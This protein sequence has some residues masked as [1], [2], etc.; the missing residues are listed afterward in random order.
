MLD[1]ASVRRWHFGTARQWLPHAVN[2]GRF[3]FG[4]VC[5]FFCL[6]M[7]YLRSCWTD[8]RQI[9][10]KEVFGLSLGRVWRFKGQGHQGQKRHFWPFQRPACVRF[11]LGKTSLVS[12][13]ITSA[14]SAKRPI[15][16]QLKSASLWS[17]FPLK[18]RGVPDPL[19][20][21]NWTLKLMQNMLLI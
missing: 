19:K 13:W 1:L 16:K 9:Y 2:C 18:S 15:F 4:A 20:C 12:S 14:K 8:L 3:C 21:Q 11:V 17:E 5:D 7:K 6:C 10:R